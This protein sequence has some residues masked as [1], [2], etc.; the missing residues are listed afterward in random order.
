MD[1]LAAVDGLVRKGAEVEVLPSPQGRVDLVF[2]KP[3]GPKV[4]LSMEELGGYWLAKSCTVTRSNGSIQS[5][6]T[7]E[8]QVVDGFPVANRVVDAIPGPASAAEGQQNRVLT[9]T[10]ASDFTRGDSQRGG[11]TFGLERLLPDGAEAASVDVFRDPMHTDPRDAVKSFLLLR[12][13]SRRDR[14]SEKVEVTK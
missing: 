9:E 14:A 13:G 2:S 8:Y 10:V 12:N 11:R 1:L 5:T 3:K 4:E 7:I 6:L